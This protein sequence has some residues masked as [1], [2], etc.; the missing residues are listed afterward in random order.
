VDAGDLKRGEVNAVFVGT[1]DFEAQQL[2]SPLYSDV[3]PANE[4]WLLNVV[5][6]RSHHVDA[7]NRLGSLPDR[8]VFFAS[9]MRLFK[10]LEHV[11]VEFDKN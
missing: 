6:I 3:R 5:W 9:R 4:T 8:R 7:R 10:G 11:I 2:R 1:L